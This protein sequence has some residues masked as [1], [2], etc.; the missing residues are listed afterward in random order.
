M[1][2]ARVSRHAPYSWKLLASSA[3][4]GRALAARLMR[5]ATDG[6][7]YHTGR[8]RA[9]AT[10][11][12]RGLDERARC[13]GQNESETRQETGRMT[14]LF[15]RSLRHLGAACTGSLSG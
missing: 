6:S 12:E 13:C 9:N 10:S 1:A 5:S 2:A 8:R 4:E 3:I 14:S 7:R 15:W 11:R